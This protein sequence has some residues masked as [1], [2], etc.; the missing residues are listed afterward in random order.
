MR[1][2]ASTV[3]CG[4]PWRSRACCPTV[5]LPAVALS[6]CPYLLHVSRKRR[7]GVGL[8]GECSR[9]QPAPGA[10]QLGHQC[11]HCAALHRAALHILC[12]PPATALPSAPPLPFTLPQGRHTDRL[13]TV[14]YLPVNLATVCAMVCL[15]GAVRPR[16]RIQAGLGGFTLALTA[17]TL[18]RFMG[19]CQCRQAV[20]DV[21]AQGGDH[22]WTGRTGATAAARL[23]AEL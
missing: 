4:L 19:G 7:L 22:Q 14:C 12:V 16:L 18:V 23:G 21:P 8:P 17:V 9:A 2:G 6:A 15:H 13:L 20:W 5:R 10:A 3:G 1:G 11:R